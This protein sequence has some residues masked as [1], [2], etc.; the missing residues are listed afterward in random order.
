M[1]KDLDSRRGMGTILCFLWQFMDT[2]LTHMTH[3]YAAPYVL[4]RLTG[5]GQLLDLYQPH[6]LSHLL[7]ALSLLGSMHISL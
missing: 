7:S 6:L 4:P 2:L 1:A 5:T 3:M